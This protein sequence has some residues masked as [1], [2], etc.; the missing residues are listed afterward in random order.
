[1]AVRSAL[2]AGRGDLIRLVMRAGLVVTAIGIVPGALLAIA[3]GRAL[4]SLLYG[5]APADP[6]TIGGAAAFLAAVALLA[7]YRPARAAASVDPM[8]ILRHV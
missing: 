6:L 1:M 8:V 4:G 2:G 7:C 5:V 3:A